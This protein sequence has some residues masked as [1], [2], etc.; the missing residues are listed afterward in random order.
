MLYEL[1]FGKELQWDK[2]GADGFYG[3][4]TTLAVK[5]FVKKSKLN[6]TGTFIDIK[7]GLSLLSR[8]NSLDELQQL[9]KDISKNNIAKK[10]DDVKSPKVKVKASNR[11]KQG[12]KKAAVGAGLLAASGLTLKK[13]KES[14]NRNKPEEK[15]NDSDRVIVKPEIK[16][17]TKPEKPSVKK[18]PSAP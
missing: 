8:H 16:K 1:G 11:Y 13:L 6:S 5:T 7:T 18:K 17:E 15:V 4:A 10:V 3:N 2:F 14:S 9:H 12:A